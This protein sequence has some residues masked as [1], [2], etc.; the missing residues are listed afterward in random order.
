MISFTCAAC[1]KNL[2]VKDEMAGKA[3]KCPCGAPVKIP[4]ASAADA[5]QP[6]PAMAPA[7]A[8]FES[9]APEAGSSRKG[10][11]LAKLLANKKLLMIGAAGLGLVILVAAVASL[12]MGGGAGIQQ[13][14]AYMPD[15]TQGVF[16]M[17]PNKLLNSSLW[18]KIRD[19][20]PDL[21]KE[22]DQVP[23]H[24]GT[25]LSNV[26]RVTSAVD[27]KTGTVELYRLSSAVSAEDLKAK[28]KPKTDH[29]VFF[30]PDGGGNKG[31][32]VE[33]T[34]TKVKDHKIYATVVDYDIGGLKFTNAYASIDGDRLA[35]SSSK[36][37]NLK[38]ILERDKPAKLNE[39]LEKAIGLADF[40]KPVAFAV[41]FKG[42]ADAGDT[43]AIKSML[44]GAPGAEALL[45]GVEVLAGDVDIDSDVHA[46]LVL[47]CKD[48]KTANDL[49]DI[50]NS[51]LTVAKLAIDNQPGMPKEMVAKVKQVMS[52]LK[53]SVS[54]NQIHASVTIAGDTVQALAKEMGKSKKE[55]FN[56]VGQPLR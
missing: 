31:P 11:L 6:A 54:D 8:G 19:D 40:S 1:G 51:L 49:K 13:D 24:L 2:R 45:G 4:A 30:N 41:N 14:L 53:I 3:G 18:A 15:N 17:Q 44:G 22:I 25:E 27:P 39:G 43:R 37:D 35:L 56:Q 29:M 36:V 16:S 32:K 5:I 34:E 50:I 47:V 55:T 52:D 46:R 21:K 12:F 33:Q 10:E 9:P 20:I 28:R 26:Q 23:N 42:M 7:P 38:V 48:A